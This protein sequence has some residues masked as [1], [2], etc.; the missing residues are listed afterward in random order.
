[1][2]WKDIES[3]KGSWVGLEIRCGER[4]PGFRKPALR[5]ESGAN[6][7]LRLVQDSAGSDEPLVRWWARQEEGYDGVHLLRSDA[8]MASSVPASALDSATVQRHA[9]LEPEQ[10]MAS[11]S[12][13][14]ARALADGPASFLHSGD[15]V[16]LGAHAVTDDWRFETGPLRGMEPYRYRWVENLRE[17]LREDPLIYLDWWRPR[18]DVLN[19]RA[20]TEADEGRVAW[21]R[22]KSREGALPP[23]LLW[24]LSCLEA[25]VIVDGHARL[26]A[27]LLEERA[28][29][30]LVAHSVHQQ[31]HE[32]DPEAQQRVL[33]TVARH[34]EELALGLPGRRPIATGSLNDLLI[35]AFD[36]RPLLFACTYGWATRRSEAQ[37]MG[38]VGARLLALGRGD[39]A[40]DFRR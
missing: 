4:E 26:R 32:R 27:A 1:M 30:L 29:D 18:R 36:N 13:V 6:G 10:R 21:W 9:D 16:L 38:E 2:Y 22:K 24:Y 34:A 33:G 8:A 7:W 11:W 35:S 12:R 39:S 28:P 37:W 19:L 23:V 5:L 25:Y 17:A 20:L 14:F 15:W 3:D 31:T 40:Q